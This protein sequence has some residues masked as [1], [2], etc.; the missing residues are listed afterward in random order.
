MLILRPFCLLTCTGQL[1]LGLVDKP[2]QGIDPFPLRGILNLDKIPHDS[3]D[4]VL[5]V[6]GGLE[7]GEL[8]AAY[9]ALLAGTRSMVLWPEGNQQEI[10][11]VASR[12]AQN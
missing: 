11:P 2:D 9:G 7:L 4:G 5:H 6:Q 1:C 3:G 8:R 12:T 10:L